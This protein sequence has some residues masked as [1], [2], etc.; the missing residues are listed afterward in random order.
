MKKRGILIG[1]FAIII[2]IVVFLYLNTL[3]YK[4]HIKSDL[5][6]KNELVQSS[7][8]K[9]YTVEKLYPIMGPYEIE[10][11]IKEN[12][13]NFRI[14]T[15]SAWNIEKGIFQA[16]FHAHTTNSDGKLS[17]VEYLD[18]AADYANKLEPKKFYIAITDHNTL[19][20][21]KDVIDI[22]EKN[23]DKY[24]NLKIAIGLE[25]YS[26]LGPKIPLVLKDIIHIHLV[27]LGINPYDEE[28]N[29]LFYQRRKGDKWNYFSY[30]FEDAISFMSKK[31][32]IGIAHP[33]RY[34]RYDN[35]I[36]YETYADYLLLKY[37]LTAP[38]AFKFSECYYQSYDVENPKIMDYINRHADIFKIKKIGD[39]DNHGTNLFEKL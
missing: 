1:L 13:D 36:H 3:T 39:I 20:S 35:V 8:V 10:E 16:N 33:A 12:S 25:V 19:K 29:Q 22:L 6:Y 21:A 38:N 9:S 32:I 14:Y 5:Q 30:K 2:C 15:P 7:G 23:P 24:R 11:F 17:L 31:G 18:A 34:I 4:N 37:R 27:A 28:L 26:E